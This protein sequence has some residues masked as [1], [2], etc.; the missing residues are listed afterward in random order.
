MIAEPDVLPDRVVLL[1]ECAKRER[2]VPRV[3]QLEQTQQELPPRSI[4]RSSSSVLRRP[5]VMARSRASAA[6]SGVSGRRVSPSPLRRSEQPAPTR[7]RRPQYGREGHAV[8]V[9]HTAHNAAKS[10]ELTSESAVDRSSR[11][12]S[13]SDTAWRT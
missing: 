9:R 11:A 13:M 1:A 10:V 8:S 3:E 4:S 2:E 5:L 12:L 7:G 6:A